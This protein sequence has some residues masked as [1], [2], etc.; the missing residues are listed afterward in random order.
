MPTPAL[1]V[2]VSSTWHD[3]RPER[4][5]VEA[6]LQ[7]FRETKFVGMEYFGSRD[8]NTSDASLVEVD[9]SQIF[10][11]ILAGRYGSGITEREYRRA[12]ARGLPCLVYQKTEANIPAEDRE[13][14]VSKIPLLSALTQEVRRE[15]VATTFTSADNLA[16]V[17]AA[18]LHRCLVDQYLSA[19][20][21]DRVADTLV[22]GAAALR[23]EYGTRIHNF[24]VEYLGT[25]GH[26]VPFGGRME[27]LA[28]LDDWLDDRDAPSYLMLAAP[29]GRGKSAL[30]VRWSQLLL[31]RPGMAVVFFPISVRFRTNL[32]SVVFAALAARV[33]R[34]HGE[35]LPDDA[36]MSVEVWRAILADYL[37]RPLPDERRLVVVLDGLDEASDWSA[38]PDLFPLAPPAS[39]RVV[40]AARSRAGDADASNWLQS[41]GW[42]QPGR[43]RA[44]NL[45]PLT[46]AGVSDVLQRMRVPLEGMGGDAGAASELYRL[47]EGDP[48]LVRL[49]VDDLASRGAKAPSLEDL[50]AIPPGLKGYFDRW[51]NE[52]R[53]LWGPER[54]PLR[55]G[56]VRAVLKLL[57]CAL[58]PLTRDDILA[59][60]PQ[61]LGHDA[62]V[63]E[64]T[65]RP[66]ARFVIGDGRDQGYVFSHPRLRNYFYDVLSAQ[67]RRDWEDRFLTWGRDVA[68]TLNDGRL[69]PEGAPPY[70]VRS[71]GAHLERSAGEPTALL[72]LVS[73]GWRRAWVAAEGSYA[74][75][76]NDVDRAWRCAE[77]IDRNEAAAERE[78]P[79]L[80]V[81]IRCALCRASVSTLA[82][83]APPELIAAL[84]KQNRWTGSKGLAYAR[85]IPQAAGRARALALLAPLLPQAQREAVLKDA[86]QAA[87]SEAYPSQRAEAL[88]Q[89]SLHLADDDR[90]Q[91]VDE[92]LIA[93]QAVEYDWVR[94]ES[95]AVVAP[96]LSEPLKAQVLK[97]AL[98]SAH[99]TRLPGIHA[100]ALS[101]VAPQL[102]EPLRQRVLGQAIV[103]VRKSGGYSEPKVLA[104]IASLL[105]DAER[106]KVLERALG[107]ARGVEHARVRAELMATVAVRLPEPLRATVLAEALSAVE[108]VWPASHRCDALAALAPYL[109]APLLDHAERLASAA[110]DE[111][112]RIQ[113]L[114]EL[115]PRLP[116]PL[117]EDALRDALTMALGIG[118][119]WLRSK[120]LTEVAE[121]LP[122]PLRRD[123][124]NGALA[125]ARSVSPRSRAESLAAAAS[126]LPEP[127]RID[128]LSEAFDVA[129]DA[130]SGG[131]DNLY[132]N[133]MAVLEPLLPEPLKEKA[134]TEII[135]AARAY[136]GATRA[137][138]LVLAMDGLPPD[139]RQRLLDEALAEA[140]ADLAP[141]SHTHSGIAAGGLAVV[142]RQLPDGPKEAVL[143]EV[144]SAVESVV[145]E[146]TRAAAVRYAAPY[147]SG[148]LL[149][150]LLTVASAI[151]NEG[152]RA[153][154]LGD[155]AD[156]LP[157]HLG[158][159]AVAAAETIK[160]PGARLRALVALASHL[161][162]R[163][164]REVQAAP[165]D[166]HDLVLRGNVQV[167]LVP[168]LA[169]LGHVEEAMRVLS[170]TTGDKPYRTMALVALAAVLAELP[171]STVYPA[172]RG[173]LRAVT[174]RGREALL[175]DL[176]PLIPVVASL[177]GND[178]V[179]ATARAVKD[180]GTWWF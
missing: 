64:E 81:E 82:A 87:R 30:L 10:V 62:F 126:R 124:L 79:Y 176:T 9:R 173:L 121:Q 49:Y 157:P 130:A 179:E 19:T 40:V 72:S 90:R 50:R 142:A 22:E 95:L 38:G 56:T 150:R 134:R 147:L 115:A 169:A 75:F 154:A 44:C 143:L 165:A 52:Q 24:L 122:D 74:G 25:P 178:A 20:N 172:W 42:D 146:S 45:A 36:G 14:D 11:L 29:A 167:K 86:M 113:L 15:H 125:A 23:T 71:Y 99:A 102:P 16:A 156:C 68:A 97:D 123:A 129:L 21:G 132:A 65:L 37:N 55:E 70:V 27:D 160:S 155:L 66:L 85:M 91:A 137:Q 5:A 51:W 141:G 32:S 93:A 92:A 163:T 133:T 100:E 135:R 120:L 54:S 107:A 145:D 76:L 1:N 136:A 117:K 7:R 103:E 89:V 47:S 177:G 43:G 58:G 83:N 73:D 162:E 63:L 116:R 140:R 17:L 13:T 127:Q 88:V 111:E 149:E 60:T 69:P 46:P 28:V 2:F 131:V 108:A 110:G 61:E 3:L 48:L 180:V 112:P 4:E 161:P 105:P 153:D 77:R 6:L 59:L 109:P 148:A 98:R 31:E 168:R 8:E 34:L 41:L 84:V 171:R 80:G 118:D 57:S 174:L 139:V 67:E 106:E 164:L 151:R 158:A 166:A 39:L 144:L 26:P 33:A 53:S 35:K 18:D 175:S 170:A 104:S 128:V 12:H 78:I 114:R 119:A 94:A 152:A 96:H 159:Q 101:A 138:L